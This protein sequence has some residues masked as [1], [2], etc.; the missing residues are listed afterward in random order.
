MKNY[1]CKNNIKSY[2]AVDGDCPEL[3]PTEKCPSKAC[4][5][6]EEFVCSSSKI[7]YRNE[8]LF[9]KVNCEKKLNMTLAH[10]GECEDINAS[11][12]NMAKHDNDPCNKPCSREMMPVCGSNGQTFNNKCLME[13]A[14]CKDSKIVKASD[15]PCDK[16]KFEKAGKIQSIAA[17]K[18]DWLK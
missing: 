17:M 14:N 6:T 8:C 11:N 16:E 13:I 2:T 1:I 12:N 5:D 3:S 9:N 4:P 10:R 18:Y 7:T 15:G